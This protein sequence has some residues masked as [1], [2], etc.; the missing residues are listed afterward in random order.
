MDYEGSPSNYYIKSNEARLMAQLV[1]YLP[2]KHEDLNS[3]LQMHV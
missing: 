1:K 2:H 3:D